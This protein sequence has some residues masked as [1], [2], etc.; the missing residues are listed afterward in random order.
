MT[1]KISF[2]SE[3]RFYPNEHFPYGIA[4]SG[5][6]IHTHAELLECHGKAYQALHAGLRAP[7]NEEEMCFLAVCRGERE[8]TTD[9]EKAWIRFCEK[10]KKQPSVSPFGC[11]P[12]SSKEEQG[13]FLVDDLD[14]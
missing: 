2:Y 12:V 7:S 13:D 10:T 3:S 14:H 8:A 5:E 1:K 4:R 9:H 11:G 6:F